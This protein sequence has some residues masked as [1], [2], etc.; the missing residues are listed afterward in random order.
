MPRA[1]VLSYYKAGGAKLAEQSLVN[2]PL[3]CVA[4]AFKCKMQGVSGPLG[5]GGGL[6]AGCPGSYLPVLTL[7]LILC[8]K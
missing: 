4:Y 3:C 5:R 1:Q 7:K 2:G 8:L 6:C